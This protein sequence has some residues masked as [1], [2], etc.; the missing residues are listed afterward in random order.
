MTG[1]LGVILAQ[2][3]LPDSL[4]ITDFG[5]L[6]I[7]G[8][9][10][11][12]LVR[13][14]DKGDDARESELTRLRAENASILQRHAEQLDA[15]Q[16]R[17][18]SLLAAESEAWRQ[19]ISKLRETSAEQLAKEQAKT[20]QKSLEKHALG[21]QLAI[22]E[23]LVYTVVAVSGSCTCGALAQIQGVIDRWQADH[24]STRRTP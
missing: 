7:V 22:A 6:G 10:V 2:S 13:R 5:G 9:I 15:Q 18:A 4:P 3:N 20:E 8:V 19:E 24:P 23:G 14:A 12:W 11:W 21:N 17:H 16:E 1:L